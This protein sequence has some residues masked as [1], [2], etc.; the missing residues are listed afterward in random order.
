[1]APIGQREDTIAALQKDAAAKSAQIDQLTRNLAQTQAALQTAQTSV[2]DLKDKL[3]AS[4]SRA[5]DLQMQLAAATTARGGSAKKLTAEAASAGEDS[6]SSAARLSRSLPPAIL[7]FFVFR[8]PSYFTELMNSSWGR[9]FT[10]AA[11]ILQIIGSVWVLRILR[12][13]QRT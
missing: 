13:S 7:V 5:A 4:D 8:D 9:G 3:T 2:A 6:S 12:N 1:M 10:I 11:I